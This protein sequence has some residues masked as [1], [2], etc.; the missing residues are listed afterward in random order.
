MIFKIT[1]IYPFT[2]EKYI[3]QL[4]QEIETVILQRWRKCPPHF[5]LGGVPEKYLEPPKGWK[6]EDASHV[7]DFDSQVQ[8]D[9]S[10]ME[11]ENWLEGAAEFSMFFHF[12]LK[13]EQFP[14]PESLS[15]A[16]L[17]ALT[18]AL[19]RLWAAFNF[20]AVTPDNAP[21]RIVYPILLKRMLEPSA[22]MDFGHIGVEFCDYEPEHCPFGQEFCSCKKCVENDEKD[23]PV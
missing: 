20:T 6:E 10:I 15:D 14:Q 3:E 4:L 9:M 8:Y 18:L 5:F 11:M 22:M 12:G 21:G 13:P 19:H 23:L 17:D 1:L 7:V 16:Q 2:M